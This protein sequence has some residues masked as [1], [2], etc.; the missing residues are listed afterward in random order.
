MYKKRLE[1]RKGNAHESCFLFSLASSLT[2]SA[3]PCGRVGGPTLFTLMIT[4]T[5]DRSSSACFSMFLALLCSESKSFVE[6]ARTGVEGDRGEDV[7]DYL[8]LACPSFHCEIDRSVFQE[9]RKQVWTR[10]AQKICS[11]DVGCSTCT[12][13]AAVE[14]I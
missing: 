14:M 6:C 7:E 5:T 8:S 3:L 11:S 1:E 2:S 4:C 10:S 13:E 9:P 12:A